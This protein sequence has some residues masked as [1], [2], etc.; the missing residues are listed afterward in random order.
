MPK[1]SDKSQ[2]QIQQLLSYVM[3]MRYMD[4]V[5]A[6]NNFK[7]DAHLKKNDLVFQT[8]DGK[9]YNLNFLKLKGNQVRTRLSLV[10]SPTSTEFVK[11]VINADLIKEEL[12]EW[13]FLVPV[14]FYE[15]LFK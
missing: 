13:H 2:Q 10:S 1:A 6:D 11:G 9:I 15:N 12:A 3:Q 4:I 5:P 7:V 8:F 14:V